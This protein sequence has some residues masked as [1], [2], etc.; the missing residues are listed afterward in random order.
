MNTPPDPR[1]FPDTQWSRI[2][3]VASGDPAQRRARLQELLTRYW[4]P[5]LDYVCALRPQAQ[6]DAEDLT[7]GF[8]AAL[9]ARVDFSELSPEL[10]SFR[11]FLKVALRRHVISVERSAKASR[12]REQATF[13]AQAPEGVPP[14]GEPSSASE[15][16]EDVF[17]RA[18]KRTVLDDM[19]ARLREELCA[20]D[21]ESHWVIFQKYCL[22]PADGISYDGLARELNLTLDQVR[23][24]LRDVRK[25]SRELL[26]D[27]VSDYLLP[28]D[29]IESELRFILGG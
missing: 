7:Q 18:W 13:E 20:S 23:N 11:G 29:D 17:D 3:A 28:D 6:Q 2:V 16:P 27:I 21:R 12:A 19:L 1:G 24:T 10:G 9:L 4:T 26:R 22:D 5:T 14:G 25:R 8:F 15:N